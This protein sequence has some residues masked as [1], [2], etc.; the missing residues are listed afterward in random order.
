ME[1]RPGTRVAVEAASTRLPAPIPLGTLAEMTQAADSAVTAA[2]PAPSDEKKAKSDDTKK[3]SSKSSAAKNPKARDAK[4]ASKGSSE[5]EMAALMEK[6]RKLIETGELAKGLSYLEVAASTLKDPAEKT[7]LFLLAARTGKT[8]GL[9]S[10]SARFYERLTKLDLPESLSVAVRV[11]LGECR[12]EIGDADGATAMFGEALALAHTPSDSA[13]ARRARAEHLL[14]LDNPGD[15]RDD[16]AALAHGGRDA[17]ERAYAGYRLGVILS[18]DGELDGALA[19]FAAIPVEAPAGADSLHEYIVRAALI[20]RADMLY[21]AE[22]FSEA[23]PLYER[24]AGAAHDADTS[25]W[26]LFQIANSERRSGRYAEAVARY[27]ELALRWPQS[28]W[29]KMARWGEG[30]ANWLLKEGG[31]EKPRVAKSSGTTSG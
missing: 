22:R 19:A 31:A 16:L 27:E 5:G 11:E 25:S 6:A 20:R 15:A 10:Q 4:G 21:R 1:P 12:A 14:A 18:A 26:A 28:R 9:C 7:H 8:H 17:M 29:A 3:K 13:L 2:K 23:L 30:E 24:A